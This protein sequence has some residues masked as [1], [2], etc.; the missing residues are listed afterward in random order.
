MKIRSRSYLISISLLALVYY[1]CA[2]LFSG[3]SGIPQDIS[4]VW[5]EVAIS[6]AVL[7]LGGIHLWPGV[8]LGEFFDALKDGMPPIVAI[9]RGAIAGLQAVIGVFL[10]TRVHLRPSLDRLRDVLA[11]IG[12]SAIGS[13]TILPTLQTLLL[14]FIKDIPWTSF[15]VTWWQ[16]WVANAA[17]IV[18]IVPVIFTVYSHRQELLLSFK[19][20]K[21]QSRLWEAIILILLLTPVCYFIFASPLA[22]KLS[23]Y[24]LDFIPFIFSIWAALRF[25]QLGTVCVNLLVCTIAIWGTAFRQS[26]FYVHTN[27]TE[28]VLL[29]LE[30]FIGVEVI[31]SLILASVVEERQKAADFLRENEASLA[32]A[33]RIT[34]LGNW[35]LDFTTQTLRWSDEIYRIFGYIPRAFPPSDELFHQALHPDDREV[36]KQSIETSLKEPG[37]YS[38]DYRLRLPNSNERIVHSEFEVISDANK[39][40]LRLIGTLQ[41]I[42]EQYQ[43]K[44]A[45]VQRES[46]LRELNQTL[47]EKVKQRTVELELKNAELARSIQMIKDTQEKLIQSEKMSSLGQLVAGVAHEINNPVTFISGNI[48]PIKTYAQDLLN[49]LELYAEELPQPSPKLQE[50]I[51]NVDLDFIQEDLPKLLGSMQAGVD[52][53][54]KIVLTLRNFSRLDEADMK[55]VDI[56][57]GIESS[58]LILQSRLKPSEQ[59]QR[60]MITT[61]YG[62]LPQIECYAGQ[63]NQ[64]FMNILTNAIDAIEEKYI[65]LE[66]NISYGGEIKIN[67]ELVNPETIQIEITDN[68]IGIPDELKH[69]IFDPF[70]TTKEVGKGT[71]LAMSISYQIIVEKHQGKIEV[72]SV[73]GQETT[74]KIELPVTQK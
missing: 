59:H 60:I 44:M 6:Q 4:P 40:P 51:E 66:E 54:R 32:N 7:F 68:G 36:V 23:G 21:N 19:L 55:P 48:E 24:P 31:V 61:D 8:A 49:L 26:Q 37:I 35:D 10:L 56:H 27:I 17:A 69:R 29:Y 9:L 58:L 74:F 43:V 64:V 67:T 72:F 62:E 57:E 1:I 18:V 38:M 52:R 42:T 63:L 12:L 25:G 53:I 2:N 46:Q 50:E 71:G 70:F 5:P 65:T 47:E 30:A 28:Q 11:L 33:Q 73:F 34:H 15:G 41:D 22:P 16:T 3:I 20:N 39:K 45:L 13:T 14:C